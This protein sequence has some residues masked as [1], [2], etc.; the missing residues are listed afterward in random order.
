MNT[1][2]IYTVCDFCRSEF[3]QDETGA[4]PAALAHQRAT[5][6][7]RF[8]ARE[9]LAAQRAGDAQYGTTRGTRG[10]SGYFNY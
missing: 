10:S 2:T 7:Q 3:P 9:S 4:A 8:H 6:H 1:N 5:G